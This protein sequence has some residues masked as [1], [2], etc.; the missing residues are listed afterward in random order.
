MPSPHP[1]SGMFDG[2]RTSMCQHN[3]TA[4]ASAQHQNSSPSIS[5]P[6]KLMSLRSRGREQFTGDKKQTDVEGGA[7]DKHA[8]SWFPRLW[9]VMRKNDRAEEQM[10]ETSLPRARLHPQ[11][12]VRVDA[13]STERLLHCQRSCKLM[14]IRPPP[15]GSETLWS[16]LEDSDVRDICLISAALVVVR[17]G[18]QIFN[19]S[20]IGRIFE[21]AIDG[22]SEALR[23]ASTVSLVIGLRLGKDVMQ[24]IT[25][26]AGP[27][28]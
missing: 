2:I 16:A 3:S 8:T 14:D 21:A 22:Q 6:T 9:N 17:V 25:L 13:P 26:L 4:P 5:R 23:C 18:K 10:D 24:L 12:T 27:L 1:R 19:Q 7:S 11:L 15:A 20:H 28:S